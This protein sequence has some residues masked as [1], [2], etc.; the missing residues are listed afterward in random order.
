MEIYFFE[1]A[2]DLNG[3]VE[4]S[5]ILKDNGGTEFEGS[6]SNSFLAIDESDIQVFNIS[7]EA[8]NDPP[9]FVIGSESELIINE[10]DGSKTVS[11]WITNIKAGPEDEINQLLT[12]SIIASKVD[13]TIFSQFPDLFSMVIVLLHLLNIHLIQISMV[14]N[15]TVN[16]SDDGGKDNNGN[17]VSEDKYFDIWIH[18]INDSPSSFNVYPRIYEYNSQFTENFV[19]TYNVNLSENPYPDFYIDTESNGEIEE[20]YFRLPYKVWLDSDN[21]IPSLLKFSWEKSS[22]IDT[23]IDLNLDSLYSLYYRLEAISSINNKKYILADRINN[24]SFPNQ[25]SISVEIDMTLTFLS[26]QIF[27]IQ[28][29]CITLNI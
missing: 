18:Q 7:V 28:I 22:D 3:E 19:N 21:Q 12:F 27:S 5:L 17:D 2:D 26:I 11:N 8:V 14:M 20:L 1:I 13:S 4:V 10:D 24:A 29:Q 6:E 15:F 25:D 16:L 23:N 9:T